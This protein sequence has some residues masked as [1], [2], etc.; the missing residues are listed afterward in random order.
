MLI[1]LKERIDVVSFENETGMWMESN[2]PQADITVRDRFGNSRVIRATLDDYLETKE[3][4]NLPNKYIVKSAEKIEEQY[5]RPMIHLSRTDGV[6][7]DI[8]VIGRDFEEGQILMV[9][10]TPTK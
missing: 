6:S 5:N 9:N 1:S 2:P 8:T 10:I 7:G 3:K 4:F